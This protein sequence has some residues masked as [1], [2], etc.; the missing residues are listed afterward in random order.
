VARW[1]PRVDAVR[2]QQSEYFPHHFSVNI[3]PTR[4]FF[5]A[6]EIPGRVLPLKSNHYSEATDW[7]GYCG[8]PIGFGGWENLPEGRRT[9]GVRQAASRSLIVF[10]S[11]L[12]VVLAPAMAGKGALAAGGASYTT[13]NA[14]VDGAGKDVCKNSAVNCNIYGAKEYVWLNGGPLSA[15]LPNGDYFF[16]VLV[17]GGQP[18]PNDGG[19]KNL[20]DDYDLYTNRTFTVTGG[21]LAYSGTHWLDDGESGPKP[22][23]KPPYIRL[24]PYTDTTNN[25]GVYTIAVCSLAN[26]YPVVPKDCKYD[27]FKVKKG[28]MDYSFFLSGRK[29]EDLYA[30]GVNDTGDPGLASWNITITGTGPD[31]NP[32][33]ATGVTDEDGYWEYQ[34][35]AYSFTGG[36][37]PVDVNLT[38]CEELQAGWTQSYPA[39]SCYNLTF[40]PTGLDSF[41]NLDFGNWRPASVTACKVRDLDGEKGGENVPVEGW[42]LSLTKEGVVQDTQPGGADG[43]YT[44]TGLTPGF[45]YDVHEETRPGWE[46]LNDPDKVFSTAKS[47]DSFSHTFVNA[48]LQGCTPGFWQGGNDFGTAGGKWLWND[49]ND[50]QWAASGGVGFNP[51]IWTTPFNTFFSPYA[52]LNGFDMMS[53]VG[54][55]GGPDDFQKAARSLVAAYLNASW[56]MN[57][58]Y[59]TAQLSTMWANAVASGNFLSLHILLDEANN[60]YNRT[61]GGPHCPISAGGY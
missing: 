50:P 43:C 48:I 51:Y 49:L 24:F 22:N 54:T 20:S 2:H 21:S 19:A 44:W 56:G 3:F 34:S 16:A 60:A 52:G 8:L 40:T 13:F 41:F 14:H 32:I 27:A 28:K 36:A 1:N 9:M 39:S 29:F 59:S 25:G 37:S 31:G 58:A 4:R 38:V 61:D 6:I 33:N 15:M 5:S 23:G 57:Y 26:G 7:T 35:P 45:S 55:G 53:L 17:P 11:I 10:L 18:N 30:D 42:M 46:A 12:G 47:G